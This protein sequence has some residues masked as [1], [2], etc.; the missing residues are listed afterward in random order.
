[1]RKMHKQPTG[2]YSPWNF[3]HE[4]G[5]RVFQRLGDTNKAIMFDLFESKGKDKASCG[6][7]IERVV[8][9]DGK[10]RVAVCKDGVWY[11]VD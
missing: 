2:P 4:E 8:M 10:E 9:K 5:D 11:W 6:I 1:M 3:D 7:L